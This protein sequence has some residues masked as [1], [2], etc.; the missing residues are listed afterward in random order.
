MTFSKLT[1]SGDIEGDDLVGLSHE[2]YATRH[3]RLPELRK[4]GTEMQIISVCTRVTNERLRALGLSPAR[5]PHER[6][7]VLDPDVVHG[8]DPALNGFVWNGHIHV[9]RRAENELSSFAHTLTHEIAHCISY[10]RATAHISRRPPGRNPEV[11]YGLIRTGL[12][13]WSHGMRF[14]GLN[15]ACTEMFAR[16]LRGRIL[17]S[18]HYQAHWNLEGFQRSFSYYAHVRL[19]NKLMFFLEENGRDPK[20]L[21]RDYLTGSF[22]FV[23]TVNALIPGA[24]SILSAMGKKPNDA[25]VATRALG[26]TALADELTA[27]E[28]ELSAADTSPA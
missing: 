9:V 20:S 24:G 18:P 16:G 13:T 11:E 8:L 12:Q 19:G 14:A 27:N 10:S 4:T 17:K 6:I 22:D 15:E 23:R 26:F 7:H 1:V 2:L 25:I 5:Y 3:S 28:P 21:F